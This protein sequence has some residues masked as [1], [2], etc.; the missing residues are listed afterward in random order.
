MEKK[1]LLKELA[2]LAPQGG[3]GAS[4]R[5]MLEAHLKRLPRA[6]KKKVV[7]EDVGEQE[8]SAGAYHVGAA[9]VQLKSFSPFVYRGDREQD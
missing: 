3:A 8:E 1:G 4:P 6:S 7:E 5:A 9:G 2:A